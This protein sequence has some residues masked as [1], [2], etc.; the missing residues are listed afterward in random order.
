M[1]YTNTSAFMTQILIDFENLDLKATR[2][3]ILSVIRR[4]E[5]IIKDKTRNQIIQGFL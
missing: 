5:N 4:Y 1:L 2:D 3:S